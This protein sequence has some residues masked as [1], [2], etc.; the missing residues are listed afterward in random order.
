M[1]SENLTKMSMGLL[2]MGLKL[3]YVRIYGKII[4]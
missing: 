1:M 3:V 2:R 4:K